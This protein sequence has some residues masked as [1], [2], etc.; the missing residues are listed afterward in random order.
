M[1]TNEVVALM[2]TI[3]I[4]ADKGAHEAATPVDGAVQMAR[5]ILDASNERRSTK[6]K[7]KRE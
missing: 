4:A 5:A 3:L 7:L 2:A 6:P 1:T